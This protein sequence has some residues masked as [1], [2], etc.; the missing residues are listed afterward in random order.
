M[1]SVLF[2]RKTLQLASMAALI[3]T[4]LVTSMADAET[5]E[6]RLA[7][8]PRGEVEIGNV[9]GTVHVTGWD[10]AEVEVKADL[11]RGAERLEFDRD[12]D[13]IRIKVVLPNRGSSGGSDLTVRVPHDSRVNINTVSADQSVEGVRGALR[14]QSVSGR[15]DSQSSG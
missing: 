1:D 6:K 7:A 10:R 9:A 5:V 3:A 14:L 4:S 12:G 13:R 8:D 15:I 11:G 2:C